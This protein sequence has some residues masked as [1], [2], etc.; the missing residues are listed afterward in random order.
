MAKAEE[1]ARLA[2]E[3]AKARLEKA[4]LAARPRKAKAEEERRLWTARWC[5]RHCGTA[6]RTAYCTPGAVVARRHGRANLQL[7]CSSFVT[8]RSML[9][10]V[11]LFQT[12]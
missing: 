11:V 12:N 9:L 2:A 3:A 5:L 6:M 10:A 1:E 8:P 7:C 4:R